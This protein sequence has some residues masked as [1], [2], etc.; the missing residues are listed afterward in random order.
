MQSK[1]NSQ[2]ETIISKEKKNGW[3]YVY[4]NLDYCHCDYRWGNLHYQSEYFNA[5]LEASILFVY[6]KKPVAIWPLMIVKH[7]ERLILNSLGGAIR[8]PLFLSNT[9]SKIKKQLCTFCLELLKLFA[10]NYQCTYKYRLELM[11]DSLS[12]WGEYIFDTCLQAESVRVGYVDLTLELD[13]IKSYFRKSYRPLINSGLKHWK[14]EIQDSLTSDFQRFHQLHIAVA[15][16]QTRSDKSWALQA[17]MIKNK[18]AFLVLLKNDS[19]DL[20]GGGFF[21]YNQNH[22]CYS[23]GVYRRDYFSYPLGHVVQYK[24][25][26]HMIKLGIRWYEL[27]EL[28]SAINQPSDKLRSISDFKSGFATDQFVRLT[29]S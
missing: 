23:V 10:T 26:E 5:S 6:Q 11:Q 22:C 21:V 3:Q 28:Y 19:G 12:K 25:I 8:E 17:Q 18:E 16:R 13:K 29:L 20:I 15:G 2:I 27:G 9:P 7:D 24:A 14:V 4:E 1:D